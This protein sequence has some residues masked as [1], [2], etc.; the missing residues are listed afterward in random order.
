MNLIDQ[1]KTITGDKSPEVATL[2]SKALL[3]MQ[4]CNEYYEQNERMDL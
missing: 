1:A 2:Q 4:G 3:L